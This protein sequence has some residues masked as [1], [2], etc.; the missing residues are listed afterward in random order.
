MKLKPR[1]E[2]YLTEIIAVRLW[3]PRLVLFFSFT[4]TCSTRGKKEDGE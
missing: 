2:K 4:D 1:K 3:I